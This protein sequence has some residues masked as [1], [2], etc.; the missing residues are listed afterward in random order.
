MRETARSPI[1]IS[2]IKTTAYGPVAL[3]F[4]DQIRTPGASQL[5]GKS[6]WGVMRVLR[7]FFLR[8]ILLGFVLAR[9]AAA[10]DIQ[11]VELAGDFA[12][13]HESVI[14]AIEGAGL[15]VTAIIPVNQML[16]RTAHDLGR[17]KSPYAEAETIQFCSARLAWL[18]VEE[19]ARQLT[20]CPLSL[21]IHSL[22]DRPGSVL[23]YRSPGRETPARTQGDELLRALVAATRRL[24]N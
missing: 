1:P 11:S 24:A 16:N 14:E 8:L 20:L 22:P 7:R 10:G 4:L 21:T 12:L 15:V 23:S 17:V 2:I 18:L 13:A 9:G 3:F 19:D 5:S 6:F